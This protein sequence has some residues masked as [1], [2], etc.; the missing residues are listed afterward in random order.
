[1]YKRQ[2]Y[3]ACA[4]ARA[5][6]SHSFHQSS[7]HALYFRRQY[8]AILAPALFRLPSRRRWFDQ[9]FGVQQDAQVGQH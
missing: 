9:M 5:Y 3:F 1:M 4:G 6:S 8:E 7:V 2:I